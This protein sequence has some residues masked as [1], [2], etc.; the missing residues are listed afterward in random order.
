MRPSSRSARPG[1]PADVFGLGATLYHAVAGARP[2]DLEGGPDADGDGAPL[3]GRSSWQDPIPL[4]ACISPRQ[5][6]EPI[7]SALDR[8]PS[9]RP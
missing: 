8:D 5:I 7:E 1:H 9:G 4:P 2:F 6:A 3:A